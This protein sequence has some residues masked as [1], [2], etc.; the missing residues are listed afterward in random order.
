MPA[1]LD[2]IDGAVIGG[3]IYIP[4]DGSD[5]NT[6]V[7]DIAAD[8]WTTIPANGGYSGRWQYQV[9]AIGTDL[10]VLGGLVGSSSTSEVWRLDT[11]TQTWSAGVS[12]QKSRTSFAAAAIN[13]AI[14]VAGGVA[15]PSFTP[16]MTAEKFDGTAWSYIAGVPDGGGAYTRWSYMADGNTEDRMWLAAGR[17]DSAWDIL[18]HAAYY[19]PASDTWTDS[20]TI[21]VL[22]Q[23]RVYTEGVVADD[24]YFYV[25]G[26]RAP[27]ASIAYGTN[28]RL[29]VFTTGEVTFVNLYL[30][31]I[32]K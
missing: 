2:S 26:G 6:Y 3:K 31:L 24:G 1:A 9:V 10:Y 5:S 11:I 7:Y 32:V 8:N 19:D 21:P 14:Y 16:D 15:F 13:G 12:M 30:P 18:N 23:G 25:I 27:D 28:E 20:P 22:N 29:K 4:G 17:R